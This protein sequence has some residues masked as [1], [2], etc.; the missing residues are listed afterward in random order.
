M[1]MEKGNTQM[2]PPLPVANASCLL[3]VFNGKITVN[4]TISLTKGESIIEEQETIRIMSAEDS[5]LVLF[6][7]NKNAEFFDGGIFSGNQR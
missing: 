7:T 1:R 3:Y 5:D 2:L 4:D 6:I